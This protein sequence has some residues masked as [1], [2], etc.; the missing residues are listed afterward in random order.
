MKDATDGGLGLGI[1]AQALL[2]ALEGISYLTTPDGTILAV[3]QPGWDEFAISARTTKVH[4]GWVI[5]QSL[6]SFVSGADVRQVQ[7]ALHDQ[8][9]SGATSRVSLH[10]RCD[11]AVTERHMRMSLTP[12][13]RESEV[14]G[15][16]YHSILLEQFTRPRI[17]L[18][19]HYNRVPDT[20][21]DGQILKICSYCHDVAWPIPQQPET[22]LWIEP[23]DYY[24]RGGTSDV[25]VSH[26]ICPVCYDRVLPSR[27][28]RV[29]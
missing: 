5:G 3:G 15:V 11:D 23:D 25:L 19:E 28:K 27:R 16:L 12:I 7:K 13:L 17:G 22:F 26:G 20:Y 21:N 2:D 14:V 10:Y 24:R 1:H 9:V 6:F 8:V 4:A 29:P 18:F